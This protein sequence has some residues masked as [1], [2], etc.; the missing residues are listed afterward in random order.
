M[1]LNEKLHYL[2]FD[3]FSLCVKDYTQK[4]A[5]FNWLKPA[6]FQ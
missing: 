3:Y 1:E 5:L 4:I 2:Q 6:Q